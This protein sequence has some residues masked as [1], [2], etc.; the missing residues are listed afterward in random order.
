MNQFDAAHHEPDSKDFAR[1]AHEMPDGVGVKTICCHQ[2]AIP[3]RL[4]VFD[5]TGQTDSPR[6][7]GVILF[8]RPLSAACYNTADREDIC[9]DVRPHP[10]PL[11][12]GEGE[13]LPA[14]RDKPAAGLVGRATKSTQS[15]P[16]LFPL[17]GG[18]GKG[19]GERQSIHLRSVS[20]LPR[21]KSE[22][23]DFQNLTTVCK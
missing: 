5:Q 18:E 8:L 10:G 13:T 14:F 22:N 19:E 11:P 9:D 16:R 3:V 2:H 20:A 4:S 17:P 21:L 23:P 15:E 1:L 12:Q 6:T 7:A